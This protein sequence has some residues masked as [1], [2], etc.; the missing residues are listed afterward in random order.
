[1]LM[2]NA[3]VKFGVCKPGIYVSRIQTRIVPDDMGPSEWEEVSRELK[4]VVTAAFKYFM[5]YSSIAEAT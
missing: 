4:Y 3:F 5:M 1:M 2:R